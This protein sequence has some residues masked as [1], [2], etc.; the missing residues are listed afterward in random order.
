MVEGLT[1]Y[2]CDQCI[3]LCDSIVKIDQRSSYKY[4]TRRNVKPSGPIRIPKPNE[5]KAKLDEYIIGQE[6]A[7][8]RVAVAVYNHYKRISNPVIDD[9]E[10]DKSNLLFIGP[11][12]TGKTLI[13]RILARIL[14][15]PF[16]LCDATKLTEAGYVGEDVE[17]ILLRLLHETDFN[18]EKAEHGIVFLDEIDKIGKTWLNPSIT[19]DV[20][21]E[22][23]QQDLLKILEGTIANV[24]PQGGRKHPEQ[25]YIQVD[26][27]HILFICA[28]TFDQLENI[29]ARR[30]GKK[31]I[32]FISERP[33][34]MQ[35]DGHEL[36]ELLLKVEPEDLVEYGLIP[37]FIGRL[38]VT[39]VLKPL[40]KDQLVNI[41]TEPKNAIIRQYQKFF[42]TE[43]ANLEFTKEALFEIAAMAI[44][45]K[46]G[47]RALRSIV[48]RFMTDIMYDLPNSKD[49]REYLITDKHIRHEEEVVPTKVKKDKDVA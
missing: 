10:I 8:R 23:V 44:K 17:S 40:N 42:Q 34:S 5:I 15:V 47:A 1:G 6:E 19:R 41:L 18:V 30:I 3:K 26:T 24:P 48:E 36:G 28:G 2:I 38:P 31:Q 33:G 7:K 39:C 35:I 37:E 9:I 43:N 22:S 13:A 12:G 29:I 49:K 32:G 14:D 4:Q 20:S 21:G 11:T 46:T 27:S 45:K 16:A 25:E